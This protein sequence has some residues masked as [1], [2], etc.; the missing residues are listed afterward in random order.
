CSMRHDKIDDALAGFTSAAGRTGASASLTSPADRDGPSR[1]LASRARGGRRSRRETLLKRR[2]CGESWAGDTARGSCGPREVLVE[3]P[4]HAS[5]P[6]FAP[7]WLFHRIWAVARRLRR[8]EELARYGLGLRPAWSDRRADREP[9]G[10][11]DRR[12]DRG[13]DRGRND[14]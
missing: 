5:Y 8:G 14:W 9:L 4:R 13:R 1:E 6:H 7:V 3:G 12:P 2:Q 11:P 10:R